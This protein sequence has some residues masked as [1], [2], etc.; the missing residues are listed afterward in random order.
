MNEIIGKCEEVNELAPFIWG[1]LGQVLVTV[2]ALQIALP[3]F[4]IIRQNSYL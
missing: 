1:T 2:S 4:C 3:Q